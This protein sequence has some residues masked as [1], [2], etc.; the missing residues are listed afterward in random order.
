MENLKFKVWAKTEKKLYK[1]EEISRIDVEEGTIYYKDGDDEEEQF[2]LQDAEL[3]P[4][5]GLKDIRKTDIYE[6]DVLYHMP[7]SEHFTVTLDYG[8]FFAEGNSGNYELYK[9]A[10][11]AFLTGNIYE[12][13]SAK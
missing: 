13:G 2:L 10:D 5:S 6:G 7:T 4:C 12:D 9:I 8:V 1:W 3:M 11:K